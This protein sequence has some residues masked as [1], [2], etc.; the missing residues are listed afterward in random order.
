MAGVLMN[1]QKEDQRKLVLLEKLQIEETV[2]AS[3]SGF[4]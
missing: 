4:D 3:M 2:I 1:M